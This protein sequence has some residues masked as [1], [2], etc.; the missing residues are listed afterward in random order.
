VFV[1]RDTVFEEDRA[2]KWSSDEQGA[3][4]GDEDPFTIEFVSVLCA[5]TEPISVLALTLRDSGMVSPARGVV[6]PSGESAARTPSPSPPPSP[7][8]PGT[9]EFV[10]PPLNT[11]DLDDDADDAPR[12]FRAMR[13]ILDPAPTPGLA[14]K[15]IVED[16]LA[17]IGEEPGSADEALQVKEWC[18]AM[19][20]ELASIEENRTWLLVHLPQGH[21][22]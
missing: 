18:G 15:S 13:N 1:S 10:S 9:V 19:T 8:M 16:L 11:S 4:V 21:R 2:W 5:R 3:L 12:R 17:A 20:E 6:S 22:A 7:A 14:D